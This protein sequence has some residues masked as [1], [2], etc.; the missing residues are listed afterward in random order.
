MNK[1]A[2]FSIFLFLFLPIILNGCGGKAGKKTEATFSILKSNITGLNGNASGGLMLWGKGPFGQSF[3]KVINAANG[4]ITIELDNGAWEFA[5]VA[6]DGVNNMEGIPRC[7]LTSVGLNGGDVGIDLNLTNLTC[8]DQVFTNGYG[9]T[10]VLNG[11]PGAK[12]FAEIDIVTCSSKGFGMITSQTDH[13]SYCS[14]TFGE[15][16][17]ISSFRIGHASFYNEGGALIIDEND[18]LESDC[19]V[20]PDNDFL[21]TPYFNARPVIG[22]GMSNFG[23]LVIGY[24]G[25]TDCGATGGD[26]GY[27][28]VGSLKGIADAPKS[29]A[30]YDGSFNRIRLHFSTSEADVCSGPRLVAGGSSFFAAGQGDNRAYAVCTEDQFNEIGGLNFVGTPMHSNANFYLLSDLDFEGVDLGSPYYNFVP[31]GESLGT[32]ATAFNG[33]FNGYNHRILNAFIDVYDV[34]DLGLIR[35]MGASSRIMNLTMVDAVINSRI[36]AATADNIGFIVGQVSG[37]GVKITNV[38]AHGYLEGASNIGGIVGLIANASGFSMNRCHISA[39]I[40]GDYN[41]GGLVGNASGPD[42]ADFIYQSSAKINIYGSNS[43]L[44]SLGGILGV[45]SG[46]S[47]AAEVSE[48]MAMGEIRGYQEIGGLIGTHETNLPLTDSYSLVSIQSS[49]SA[50]NHSGGGAIGGYNGGNVNRV[51]ATNGIYDGDT[52]TDSNSLGGFVGLD[53][54]TGCTGVSNSFYTGYNN[55]NGCGTT[56]TIANINTYATYS[57]PWAGFIS[58]TNNS[59]TWY[60]PASDDTYDFPMLSWESKI[61]PDTGQYYYDEVPYLKRR[62][63]GSF[64]AGPIAPGAGTATDPKRICT[65]N[66]FNGMTT[67]TYY[68]MLRDLD[69]TGSPDQPGYAF[70]AGVY[71]LDG[72]GHKLISPSIK[73]QDGNNGI[74]E[75]LLAGS[76]IQN[77]E[78][79]G[80]DTRNDFGAP[81]AVTGADVII[82][83]LAGEN[84]GTIDNVRLQGSISINNMTGITNNFY[85]GGIVGKNQATNGVI[86]S[87]RTDVYITASDN[88]VGANNFRLAGAVADNLG[89]ITETSSQ[90]SIYFNSSSGPNDSGPNTILSGFVAV[91]IS[92]TISKST[93]RSWISSF[94]SGAGYANIAGVSYLNSGTI[95]DF[96]SLATFNLDRMTGGSVFALVGNNGTGTMTR[97]VSDNSNGSGNSYTTGTPGTLVSVGTTSGTTKDVIC[98]DISGAPN[99]VDC[100]IFGSIYTLSTA[101]AFSASTTYTQGGNGNNTQGIFFADFDSDGDLD[102]VVVNRQ[103]NQFQVMENDGSGGF[104]GGSTVA[105]GVST[106]PDNL[107]VANINTASDTFLDIITSNSGSAGDFSVSIGTS[108]MTFGTT[109]NYVM[110]GTLT[111]CAVGLLN[112]ADSF[113][114]VVCTDFSS[115][116]WV[117]LGDGSGSFGPQVSFAT[118]TSPVDLV[119]ADF[120]GDSYLDVITANFSGNTIS[121]MAGDGT[122]SF[123]AKVDFSVTAAPQAM[124]FADINEDGELDIVVVGSSMDEAEIMFGNGLGSFTTGGTF[125]VGATPYD[126]WIDDVN[127]DSNLDLIVAENGDATITIYSGDGVGNFDQSNFAI[128]DADDPLGI[129]YG[130]LDGDGEKDLAVSLRA[131]GAFATRFGFGAITETIVNSDYG[132]LGTTTATAWDITDDYFDD[133]TTVWILENGKLNLEAAEGNLE[134]ITPKF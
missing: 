18:I 131:E 89:T 134:S 93:T 47:G 60:H 4:T 15:K 16:G 112:N 117:R 77:F 54:P 108:G 33:F 110:G 55:A 50:T 5:A 17:F 2:L 124:D 103:L 99:I 109:T 121:F 98:H 43:P 56:T 35:N 11:S 34:D 82:G 115:N 78:V 19:Q 125:P 20:V 32:P 127:G 83:G 3:G 45:S 118:D 96:L 38:K 22:D 74:F 123:L 49:Q 86:S 116:I 105:T 114:D 63:S 94:D 130:D 53:I 64:T 100:S 25:S 36:D 65:T 48:V 8:E 7:A 61:N 23:T 12:T 90:G 62:C 106:F 81:Y 13:I 21:P 66:Q 1:R 95:T 80:L 44:A 59:T 27:K 14:N 71:R 51:F 70:A 29:Y 30:F 128:Y 101:G 46:A 37:G 79:I 58:Q 41:I 72:N 113:P 24:Y 40:E 104:F 31:I 129:F 119:I 57:G 132:A 91:N 39:E 6:W 84:F 92:G 120:N 88:P 85:V 9:G 26:K 28:I 111:N 75:T 67:S 107:V 10:P 126:V 68:K 42:M 97:V 76:I 102:S 133:T 69:I 73:V 52:S 122:G 87:V